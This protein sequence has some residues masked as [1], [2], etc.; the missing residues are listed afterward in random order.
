MSGIV[1]RALGVKNFGPFKDG[2]YFTTDTDTSK[3]NSGTTLFPKEILL[4]IVFLI[5]SV[6]T[7]LANL[8]FVKLSFRFKV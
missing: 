7:A 5:F 4:S 2:V 1:L 6:Q 3:K 8:I